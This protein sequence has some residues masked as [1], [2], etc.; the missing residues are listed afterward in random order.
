MT[1]SSSSNEA[2]PGVW[3]WHASDGSDLRTMHD[4]IFMKTQ[5]GCRIFECA[6]GGASRAVESLL[7]VCGFRQGASSGAEVVVTEVEDRGVVLQ[8]GFWVPSGEELELEMVIRA[9]LSGNL[10]GFFPVLAAVATFHRSP[11]LAFE[12]VWAAAGKPRIVLRQP[13]VADGPGGM[14]APSSLLQASWG[15]VRY[16]LSCQAAGESQP[17]S[18]TSEPSQETT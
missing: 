17:E 1:S 16:A 9:S 6:T 13:D 15:S 12:H 2:D 18:A 3:I 11:A 4:F 8:R 10:G 14:P 7:G 5:D